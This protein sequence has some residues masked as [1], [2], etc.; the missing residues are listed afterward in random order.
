MWKIG[1]YPIKTRKPFSLRQ[2][3]HLPV[4]VLP[5]VLHSWSFWRGV[6]GPSFPGP[7]SSPSQLVLWRGGTQDL[8]PG[9]GGIQ[10]LLL[11]GGVPR[12]SFGGGV[13]R[14]SF[15]GGTQVLLPGGVPGPC[16]HQVLPAVLP[17]WSFWGG[18]GYPGLLPPG[19]SSSPS[20]L[21]L[22]RGSPQC[23]MGKVT[24]DPPEYYRIEL[25]RLTN[26]TENITFPQ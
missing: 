23:I 20:Q 10:D 4:E 17:R 5:A 13:P 24:W 9:G 19:P 12:F 15:W 6:P 2:T 18:R 3:S 1:E 25:N 16:F 21:V 11:G 14:T 7:Y 26:T 22:L 8:L